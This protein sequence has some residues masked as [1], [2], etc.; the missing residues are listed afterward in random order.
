MDEIRKNQIIH[1]ELKDKTVGV[2]G[3]G[4]VPD[5]TFKAVLTKNSMHAI[6]AD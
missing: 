5:L 6:I 4:L 2:I 3:Q 1:L